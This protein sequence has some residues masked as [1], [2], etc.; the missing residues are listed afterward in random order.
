[1]Y[2]DATGYEPPEI[3]VFAAA[4]GVYA[5]CDCGW[6][7]EG[8]EQQGISPAL[9]AAINR[10]EAESGHPWPSYTAKLT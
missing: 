10:H 9:E 4:R 5:Q 7:T 2:D 8:Y 6:R 1:M 3:L